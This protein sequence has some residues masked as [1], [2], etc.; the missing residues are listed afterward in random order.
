MAKK[1]IKTPQIAVS[2]QPYIELPTDIKGELVAQTIGYDHL[3]YGLFACKDLDYRETAQSG[4]S[5][6]KINPNET[7]SYR[8]LAYSK[9]GRLRRSILL[10]RF[11]HRAY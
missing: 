10:H 4:A 3:W 11:S 2:V 7:Q 5:F 1:N 9:E 8:I 6:A